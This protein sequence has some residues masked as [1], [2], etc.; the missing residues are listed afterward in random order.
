MTKA[1][2]KKQLMEV[3][4]WLYRDVKSGK[5]RSKAGIVRMAVLYAV[6]FGVLGSVFFV[7]ADSICAPFLSVGLGWL[8]WC[9]MGLVALFLGVFGSVFNTY[10]SLYQA[11]DNDLLFAMPIPP[12][13][14][15]T[16]RLSGVYA[17]GLMYELIVMIPTVI[18]RF[19]YAPVCV[20]SVS[21]SLLMP[22]LLSVLVL[23]LSAVL[24][25]VVALVT[26]KLKRKNILT[27]LI[28]LLFICAY[29]FINSQSSVILQKIL[30]APDQVGGTMRN[31]LYPLYCM[32]MAAEGNA[33]YMLLFAAIVAVLIAAVYFV[34][35]RSFLKLATTNRG[36]RKAVYREKRVKRSS[37]AGA[38]LRKELCRFKG[39][40]NYMLNCGLGM[41][42]LPA[43]AV[44][45]IWKAEEL[46]MLFSELLPTEYAPLIAAAMICMVLTMN[47]MT[48]PSVSLEGKTLWLSQALP[49]PASRVLAAKLKM[50]C[51]LTLPVALLPVAAAVWVFRIPFVSALLLAV[52]VALFTLLTAELGLVM[53]LKMPN[54]HWTSEVV[55]IKQGGGVLL[56]LLIAWATVIVLGAVYYLLRSFLAP[57]LF[58]ALCCCV[59]G[60]ACGLLLRWLMN[61]GAAI[62]ETL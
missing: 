24:G 30:A 54:L 41:V 45:L 42:F 1:L 14:I 43:T 8:Y 10:A 34:M 29:Y 13:H 25:W 44:I 49:V 17:M 21:F 22:L 39:S 23:V 4:S 35:S 19:R 56:S 5:A 38:L 37:A 11:K 20:E 59:L 51:L 50:H 53:N 7:L 15:L 9:L 62:F 2:F 52:T 61:R 36:E 58:S 47:D 33:W 26:S 27:V 32:G 48:A 18:V 55:P 40:A 3:F 46:R 28:S 57:V 16:A 31:A 6:L 60:A 12:S